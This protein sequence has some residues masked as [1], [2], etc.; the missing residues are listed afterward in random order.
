MAEIR[1][2]DGRLTFLAHNFQS[3]VLVYPVRHIVG[4]IAG[5]RI[6]VLHRSRWQEGQYWLYDEG[7]YD[8]WFA[9]DPEV[10]VQIHL[11]MIPTSLGLKD[12][13]EVLKTTP[14]LPMD[15]T[16]APL[17]WDRRDVI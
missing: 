3:Q 5:Q 7:V 1:L 2:V 14:G 16:D 9:T 13:V 12:T 4:E 17:R 8:I 15:F 10:Y 11:E 6:K